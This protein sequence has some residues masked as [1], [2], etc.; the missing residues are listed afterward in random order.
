M[1]WFYG[2]LLAAG[3]PL[4]AR[5]RH[6]Q[7]AG[8]RRHRGAPAGDRPRRRLR[9]SRRVL[10]APRPGRCASSASS[11]RASATSAP[12]RPRELQRASAR[13]SSA[14]SDHTGGL[15]NQDGLDIPALAATGSAEHGFLEGCPIGDAGRPRRRSSRC[16]CDILIPA[17]LE[18][19]ITDEN[20][21]ALDCQ[22]I[23]EAANGPTTPE[24]E[25]HPRASA[26]SSSSPTSSP[27]PAASPF[28]TS[29]G[30]RTS[31]STSWDVDRGPGAPAPPAARGAR[32]ASSTPPSA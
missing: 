9:A 10:R 5:D 2:H 16:P 11:S 13:R 17:A 23:V 26:A 3:G 15:V 24:A 18:R 25:A 14:V 31:R 27:T 6:R 29:S 28:A 20:A 4:G 8:A 21:T 30:S 12:S 19:Q 1:A 32:A 22:L 7:A